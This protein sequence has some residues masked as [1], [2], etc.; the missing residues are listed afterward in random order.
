MKVIPIESYTQG[1]TADLIQHANE[2]PEILLEFFD[3]FIKFKDL[4]EGEEQLRVDLL[5]KIALIDTL[6]TEVNKIGDLKSQKADVERKLE[7]QAKNKLNDLINLEQNLQKGREFRTDLVDDL[8]NAINS[9]KQVLSDKTYFNQIKEQDFESIKVGKSSLDAILEEVN[10]IEEIIDSAG[11]KIQSESKSVIKSI[12]KNLQSWRTEESIILAK[13]DV[14]KKE[15]EE[16]GIKFDLAFIRQLTKQ[17]VQIDKKLTQLKI[18]RKQYKEELK[19][20]ETMIK[21]RKNLKSR[22]YLLR[23]TW[24]EKIN[25]LLA[26][27]ITDYDISIKFDEG[28]FSEELIEFLMNEINWY[29]TKTPKMRAITEAFHPYDLVSIL[30]NKDRAKFRGMTLS[31]GGSLF[32]K[33]ELDSIMSLNKPDVL[34]RIKTIR[35]DDFPR[36]YVTK[37]ERD[38]EGKVVFRRQNFTKLSLGQQQSILLSILLYSDNK[39]PLLIDQPE[40]NLDSE[41]IYKTIVKNLRRVKEMR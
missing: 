10:K 37:K 16:K 27:T 12:K 23:R 14:K 29:K 36:L 18:K 41:F 21:K 33:D 5:E 32:S 6:R 25:Q 30:K 7:V 20:E 28:K 11:A 38:Q 22:I 3:E 19:N 26:E 2:N 35:F 8:K 24:G 17:K 1:R 9:V 40:D 39:Y 31:D 15:L 34:N 13:I 4:K